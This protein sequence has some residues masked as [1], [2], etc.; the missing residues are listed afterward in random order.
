MQ[1]CVSREAMFS[2][3]GAHLQCQVEI[4]ARW[5][6]GGNGGQEECKTKVSPSASQPFS[7]RTKWGCCG[8]QERAVWDFRVYEACL[9]VHML[10]VTWA[11]RGLMW[12]RQLKTQVGTTERG[13]A[14]ETS[15]SDP[16][17]NHSTLLLLSLNYYC[18]PRPC[19]NAT[20]SRG[21]S[22]M[23]LA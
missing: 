1:T 3:R 5:V 15:S 6:V 7:L 2:L 9:S 14:A 20:S 17:C 11:N 19:S 10:L 12:S 8:E 21:P 22:K 23:P 4:M 18:F 13:D 16:K